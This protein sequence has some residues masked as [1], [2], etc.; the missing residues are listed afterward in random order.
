MG[1]EESS[2]SGDAPGVSSACPRGPVVVR[3]HAVTASWWPASEWNDGS[4]GQREQR[5][6]NDVKKQ[7]QQIGND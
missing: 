3:A 7:V 4:V 2:G 6:Q 1:T 5:L